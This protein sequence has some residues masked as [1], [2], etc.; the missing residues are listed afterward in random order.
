MVG[1]MLELLEKLAEAKIE[2]EPTVIG[3]PFSATD[4]HID[5]LVYELHGFTNE[6][7]QIVEEAT[8]R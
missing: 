4:Y 7:I 6:E 2:Q 8:V 3:R 5:N 1:R